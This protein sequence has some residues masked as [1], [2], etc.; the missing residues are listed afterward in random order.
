MNFIAKKVG[1][2]SNTMPSL[3]Y[4]FKLKEIWILLKKRWDFSTKQC[5]FFE[6]NINDKSLRNPWSFLIYP[7]LIK[8]FVGFS[9]M[10]CLLLPTNYNE[11]TKEKYIL[12]SFFG[13]KGKNK[14]IEKKV[15]S[16]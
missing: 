1:S 2:F 3:I 10:I 13:I 5:Y 6:I 4:F 8:R 16:Q 9:V 12:F 11:N 15:M 14:A 7:D